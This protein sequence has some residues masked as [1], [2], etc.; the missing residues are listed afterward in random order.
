[1]RDE[2]NPE[3]KPVFNES[4]LEVKPVYTAEDVDRSGNIR[5]DWGDAI[6]ITSTDSWDDNKPSG[7]IQDLPVIEAAAG[8]ASATLGS[9]PSP[10]A[11]TSSCTASALG[12]CV[13]TLVSGSRKRAMNGFVT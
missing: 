3:V 9:F 13:S 6:R 8:R 7:C 10:G 12:P 11:F 4:G 1:M 5:F 2:P